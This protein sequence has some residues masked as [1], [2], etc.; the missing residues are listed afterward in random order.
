MSEQTFHF[1]LGPVQGFVAQARRTRDFWAGSFLLS[2]LAGAAMQAVKQQGGTIAFPK[3]DDEAIAWLTGAGRGKP[4]RQGSIPNRFKAIQCRVPD[5]FEPGRVTE[6]VHQAW[7]ALAEAVWRHDLSHLPANSTTRAIWDRQINGFWEISWVL[8]EASN[9]LDRRKNWRSHRPPEE[10]GVKCSVMAGWQELS[11]AVRPGDDTLEAFWGPLRRRSPRDFDEAERLCAIAFVKRRFVAVFADV[12]APMPRPQS[13]DWTLHGW[14]L[15]GQMPSTLDLAAAHWV[16]RLAGADGAA[17]QRLHTATNALL[18]EPSDRGLALPRC[19]R[20]TDNPQLAGLHTSAL[21]PHVLDNPKLC[22]DRRRVQAVRR[23]LKD[24][25]CQRAPAPFYAILLMDGDSL[26]QL[27]QEGNAKTPEMI[28]A[29][30]NRFTG[31]VPNLVD[32]HSGFL[33]YAGGD[34]VLAL[35]PLE[36]A[37]GC[38]AAIRTAY[39]DAFNWAFATNEPPSTLSGA[40]TF[41]HVKIPL[42]RLL[43]DSHHLL[44]D[45][46]KDATGRDALAV[47]VVKQSGETLQWARPWAC[48]WSERAPQQ[49]LAIEQIAEEFA[50]QTTDALGSEAGA[51][52]NQFFYRV[53]ERFQFLNPPKQSPHDTAVFSQKEATALLAVDYLAS[54]A[55][56]TRKL[57]LPQAQHLIRPLLEQCYPV[58]RVPADQA[59]PTGSTPLSCG[60]PQA[61]VTYHQQPCLEAD[62]ALL[63]RFLAQKGADDA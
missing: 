30:L 20:E 45:I 34:D 22:P 14:R 6:T 4:P 16:A 36:S 62:G 25:A 8:G 42:T 39:L 41:A 61:G 26:G 56:R 9:L 50:A 59:P 5:T 35:L 32:A 2:W 21:F 11:G 54:G 17:L 63:V 13:D 28:S 52:S 12:R 46:A 49:R 18:D 38:A 57:T 3:P 27:L 15:D 58:R 23:A 44:D 43:H 19:V 60:D 1:T 37:L 29:A 31:E 24:L 47:R 48:A 33:I 10:G 55:N 53:R 40:V 7:Q 51:F